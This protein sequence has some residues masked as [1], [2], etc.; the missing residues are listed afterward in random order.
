MASLEQ[1]EPGAL[2]KRVALTMGIEAD[3][4]E[5]ARMITPKINDGRPHE[6]LE[7]ARK[8]YAN[9]RRD[10]DDLLLDGVD[11]DRPLRRELEDG[12]RVEP[13]VLRETTARLPY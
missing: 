11:L 6:F 2:G 9:A 13:K 4:V 12:E 3:V 8:H 5:F 1:R 10:L 7:K